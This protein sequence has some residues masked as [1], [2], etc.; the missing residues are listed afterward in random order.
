[1]VAFGLGVLHPVL[2]AQF[3]LVDDHEILHLVDPST[4]SL[5][6]ELATEILGIDPAAG[7]LRPV[8]WMVRI[9]Q[10][11]LFRDSAQAWHASVLA[12]ALAS[13]FLLYATARSLKLQPVLAGLLAA[14]LLV[15]P[16]ASSDW[17]RLGANETI[18]TPLFLLA[19]LAGARGWN[20]VFVISA[21]GAMLAKESFALTAPVVA[22]GRLM[23]D[24]RDW[25]APAIILACGVVTAGAG[26]VLAA[27]A[28]GQSYGGAFLNPP[29]MTRY[30][31]DSLHNLA[32]VAFASNGWLAVLA[33]RQRPRWTWLGLMLLLVVPQLLLYSRQ[34]VFEGKYEFP[35][36]IAFAAWTTALV[37]SARARTYSFGL[38][39]SSVAVGLYALSTWSYAN[40]FA[41]DSVQLQRTVETVALAAPASST[42]G[43]AGNPAYDY[44][45]IESFVDHLKHV[46]RGDLRI[47]LLATPPDAA[48]S[49]HESDLATA[50]EA[51]PL[52]IDNP[53][54]T[55]SCDAVAAVIVLR[56]EAFALR[57]VPCLR[58]F[59][60]QDLS[61]EVLLWGGDQVSLKPRLPGFAREGYIVLVRTS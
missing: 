52:G 24:R 23:L 1:M 58:D 61:Q 36:V 43:I 27:R 32:I 19:L 48:Y 2:S 28:G 31:Q 57:A 50:L 8:Y 30:I 44:E 55:G 10:V 46:G 12:L 3:V 42:V 5:G 18:A 14:W 29:G 47:K 41:L 20:A 4:G 21:A 35:A 26:F 15:P 7:R 60:R 17:V 59:R 40:A 34:G 9:A 53:L 22:A 56:D 51:S 25:R 39:L 54:M 6:S 16:G 37:A 45:P 33:A 11:G 49:P 13:A 38:T